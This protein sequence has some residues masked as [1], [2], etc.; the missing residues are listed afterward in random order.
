MNATKLNF[1][2][3]KKVYFLILI[4]VIVNTVFSQTNSANF[5]SINWLIGNWQKANS[6]TKKT[7]IENWHKVSETEFAGMGFTLKGKDTIFV[8]KLKI[9]LQNNDLYYVADVKE[10]K[11]TTLF[12][13]TS[14]TKNGFIC[15]NPKHNFPKKIEYKLNTKHLT[16]IISDDKKKAKFEFDRR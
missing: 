13:F 10:N 7:S 1:T 3:F 5:K 8:E 12:K 16:V 9:I 4:L 6:I 11:E 14:I 2:T 15:K